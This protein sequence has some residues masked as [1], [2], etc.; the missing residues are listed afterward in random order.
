LSWNDFQSGSQF[1]LPEGQKEK[2]GR[3]ELMFFTIGG[4]VIAGLLN[5]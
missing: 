3:L 5:V 2:R 1:I 4:S